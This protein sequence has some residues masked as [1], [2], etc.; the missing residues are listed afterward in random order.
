MFD[1]RDHD[2]PTVRRI[3]L[4]TQL[5]ERREARGITRGEAARAIGASESKISRLEGG[6]A[7][8][9]TADVSELL[10]CYDVLGVE[11]DALMEMARYANVPG[12]WHEYSNVLPDWFETYV[13]LESAAAVIHTYEPLLI[14]GL[15]QTEPYARTIERTRPLRTDRE[16]E[17]RVELRKTRQELILGGGGRKLWAVVDEG[18]LRRPVGGH[19]VMRQQ[20]AHLLDVGTV[21]NGNVSIQV[22]PFAAGAEVAGEV[23][24]FSVFRFREQEL[25][26]IAY[27]EHLVSAVYMD[28]LSDTDQYRSAFEAL[29]LASLKPG[30]ETNDVIEKIMGTY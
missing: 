11:R 10:T 18:A 4:G 23:G 6:K 8:F 29:S 2:G 25:P 14:P 15:L 7:P 28:K 1:H 22:L 20:L 19:Q 3:I 9:K 16:V 5:R 21:P 24:A 13:G 30:R 12:W 26:V 27:V 17:R